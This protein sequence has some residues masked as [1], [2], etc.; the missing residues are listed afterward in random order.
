MFQKILF[1]I[2]LFFFLH[3]AVFAN[4]KVE[5]VF[6]D[7]DSNYKYLSE[8]QILYSKG[9]IQPNIHNKFNPYELLSREEFVGILME[10]NCVQCTKPN[11]SYDLIDDFK[12]SDVYYDVHNN[13][14]YFY[15]ISK[16][17]N[18]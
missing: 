9:I 10:T 16:A 11:V 14:D 1:F 5:D 12:N 15:C 6:I 18:E 13:S 8:L 2:T 17:D 4:Q 3:T 7:I